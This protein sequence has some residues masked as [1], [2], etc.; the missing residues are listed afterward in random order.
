MGSRAVGTAR[1]RRGIA[2]QARNRSITPSPEKRKGESY[3]L[4]RLLKKEKSC[5]NGRVSTTT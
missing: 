1:T 4:W 5:S 3:R 2:R